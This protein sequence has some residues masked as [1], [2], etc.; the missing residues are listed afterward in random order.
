MRHDYGY[1]EEKDLGKPYDVRMLARLLPLLRPHGWLLVAAVAL[2]AV[3]TLM[4]LC[5]PLVTKHAIDQYIVPYQTQTNL[6][7]NPDESRKTRLLEIDLNNARAAAVVAA[8]PQLFS[9]ENHRARIH[10]SDLHKLPPDQR[11]QLRADHRRGITLLTIVFLAVVI[12]NFLGN[13]AQVI[14]KEAIGQ[15]V[16]HDLRTRLFRHLQDLSIAFFNR[17]PV[18]RLVTRV[19][20]DTQN[21][22]ELFT[23]VIAFLFQD[24]FLLIGI[25]VVLISIDWQ[26]ALVS[27]AVLPVVFLASIYFAGQA[28]SAYR[29]M[30]IKIA[31]INTRFQETISGIRVLQLF[32]Q[33][34]AS[35]DAFRQINHDYFLAGMRQIHVFA[36]FMPAI[37]FFSVTALA[38]I[39]WYG[40]GQVIADRI[41][42]GALVAFI[43]YLKMF[44]RPLRDIA[45]KYNVMQNAISSAERIFLLL[46]TDDPE[47]RQATPP[48]T[49]NQT[50]S[51]GP[52]ESVQLENLTFSYIA[53]EPVLTDVNFTIRAGETVALVGPT[54]S[55][56]TTIVNLLARFYPPDKGHIRFN[57][58]DIADWP[59]R[60]LRARLA[61]VNQDPFLFADTIR[62]NVFSGQN[63]RTDAQ[64]RAVLQAANCL[65]FVDKLPHGID[66]PLSEGGLSLSSGQRQL[67]S[68][69]RALAREPE[70][71][72]LDEATS[73]IDSETEERIQEA[74]GRLTSRRTTLLVAHRL[75][76]ARRA[77][78][79]IVLSGGRAIES[80]THDQLMD[81]KGL[82]YRLHQVQE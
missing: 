64:M 27:F 74:L 7:E 59:L 26:L 47:E 24:L 31:Q 65:D 60:E 66:T 19:T 16:T 6:A 13:F 20:N 46:D 56:K 21:L 32:Q 22:N 23:S 33:E 8:H 2:I 30:Q 79:I 14:V 3:T 38:L 51:T 58:I 12:I 70:L 76:T 73:Y 29:T 41:T 18:G 55:G 54:G 5:M 49:G 81:Q 52:L 67:I 42:L 78:R 44:F 82:Y 68:I 63:H 75:S 45:E 36:L 48:H 25:A 17:N 61:M 62:E 15:W 28:R 71:I 80:G 9:V 37:E 4:D 69:A 35:S 77:N 57:D 11:I 40:G 10:Y 72:I 1:I 43:S 50:G 53:G 34:K 39:I